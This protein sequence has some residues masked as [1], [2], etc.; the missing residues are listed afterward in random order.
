MHSGIS[1]SV[2]LAMASIMLFSSSYSAFFALLSAIVVSNSLRHSSTVLSLSL[3]SFTNSSSMA[4]FFILNGFYADFKY[5]GFACE[6]RGVLGGESDVDIFVSP[7]FMP[8]SWLSSGDKGV[9]ADFESLVFGCAALKLDAVHAARVVKGDDVA[10]RNLRAFGFVNQ[11]AAG[12][13]FS[14][15]DRFE[16]F[17]GH[18][19]FGLDE[20]KSLVLSECKPGSDC[21]SDDGFHSV[22]ADFLYVD[23]GSADNVEFVIFY[24]FAVMLIKSYIKRVLVENLDAVAFYDNVHGH[25][26]LSETFYRKLVFGLFISLVDGLRPLFLGYV[27]AISIFALLSS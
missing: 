8:T 23:V 18:V 11:S 1:I 9:A 20:G 26:A 16:F 12:F 13:L 2:L 4:E 17:A 7:T 6:L 22:F 27:K 24:N 10:R 5:G 3:M 21:R 15:H 19:D 25:L 14:L